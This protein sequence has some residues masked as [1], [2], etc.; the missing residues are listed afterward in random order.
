MKTE[1]KIDDTIVDIVTY[2]IKYT[3]I[4]GTKILGKTWTGNNL[5]LIKNRYYLKILY[6]WENYQKNFKRY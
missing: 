6:S 1:I 4:S 2:I 5:E 3:D